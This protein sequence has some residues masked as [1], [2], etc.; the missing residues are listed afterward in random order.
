[1][2]L[3][4][5]QLKVLERK[6]RP[7]YGKFVALSA[8]TRSAKFALSRFVVADQMD[9]NDYKGA[10]QNIDKLMK[11]FVNNPY[12]LVLK[13]LTLIKLNRTIEADGIITKARPHC[14]G[15]EQCLQTIALCYRDIGQCKIELPML[16]V[17]VNYPFY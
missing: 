13:A 10:Q 15:D 2:A 4:Q 16:I 8:T 11:K 9:A 6:L 17:F 14:L 1:M 5:S 3:S 12:L 7:I